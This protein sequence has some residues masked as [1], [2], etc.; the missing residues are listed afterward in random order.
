MSL[1]SSILFLFIISRED[2][3]PKI[4]LNMWRSVS[5]L[6]SHVPPTQIQHHHLLATFALSPPTMADVQH[7]RVPREVGHP[8][9]V[10]LGVARH[11][12]H[13]SPRPGPD[14]DDAFLDVPMCKVRKTS[15]PNTPWPSVGTLSGG[16]REMKVTLAWDPRMLLLFRGCTVERY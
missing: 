13:P 15:A 16:I 5:L 11:S 14:S 2:A 8:W 12:P 9:R 7:G 1:L 4:Y 6:S 3:T 10:P